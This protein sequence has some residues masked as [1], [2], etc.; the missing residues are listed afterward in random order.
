MPSSEPVIAD[1][2]CATTEVTTTEADGAIKEVS[3]TMHT[4]VNEDGSVTTVQ[5]VTTTIV[6]T[7]GEQ[8]MISTET[9]VDESG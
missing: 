6:S 2:P 8:E 3:K 5:E 1:Q 4:E 9:A 7:N